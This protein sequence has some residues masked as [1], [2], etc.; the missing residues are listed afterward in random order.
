M[1]Q[2]FVPMTVQSNMKNL[3]GCLVVIGER[4]SQTQFQPNPY[5]VNALW[6]LVLDRSSLKQVYSQSSTDNDNPPQGLAQYLTSDF[7]LCVVSNALNTDNVPQGPLYDLLV[8]VALR[9]RA[10]V[11]P[12]RPDER[13]L[14]HRLAQRGFGPWRVLLVVTGCTLATGLGGVALP[15]LDPVS[16]MLVAAQSAVVL[17]VLALLELAPNAAAAP[18]R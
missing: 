10:G 12:W 3:T 15:R 9:L 17:L 6:F 8:V 13:H 4:G 16:A 1:A 14:P 18:Q 7:I 11:A 5:T 2:T